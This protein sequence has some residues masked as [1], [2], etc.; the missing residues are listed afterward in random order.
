MRRAVASQKDAAIVLA[1]KDAFHDQPL[2]VTSHDQIAQRR[3][4]VRI[5]EQPVAVA[6]AGF[7]RMTGHGDTIAP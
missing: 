1:I 4:N 5:Y 3:L 2:A 6:Q 7:H